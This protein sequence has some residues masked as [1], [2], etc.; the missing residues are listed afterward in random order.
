[1]DQ[2]VAVTGDGINDV[3]AL[4]SA[5]VGLAMGSGCT[6]ARYASDLI[7][8]DNDFEAAIKAIQWGRNIY[9]NITRFLQFQITIN[10]SVLFV[11]LVGIFFYAE[12]PLSAIQLL[13]V[14]L[15]MDSGAALALATEP[16]LK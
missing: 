6:A 9:H 14:N 16:P 12:P 4:Q 10:I 1:L 7:L 11:V 5:D 8:T 2:V 15:I 3:E 13:W